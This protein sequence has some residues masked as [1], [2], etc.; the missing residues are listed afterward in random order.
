MN[1]NSLEYFENFDKCIRLTDFESIFLKR[2]SDN[3]VEVSHFDSLVG[4][5]TKLASYKSG[6]WKGYNPPNLSKMFCIF[7][8]YRN[9]KPALIRFLTP[10]DYPYEIKR[11]EKVFVCFKKRFHITIRKTKKNLHLDSFEFFD[12]N[13]KH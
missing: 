8:K 11:I 3:T 10:N 12:N 7:K 1:N 6:R 9:V 4:S 2:L 5:I 13:K